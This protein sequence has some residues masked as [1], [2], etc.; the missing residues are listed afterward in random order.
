M[1]NMG[2][3]GRLM[4]F[5]RSYLDNRTFQVRNGTLSDTFEQENGLVQGGVISPILFNIMIDDVCGNVPSEVSRAL[6]A[7]DCSLWVQGRRIFHLV[8]KMQG[9]LNHVSA[10]ADRWG[11]LFSPHKCNAIVFRRYMKARE[12]TN[13]P[14]LHIYN[15]PLTYTDTVKFLGVMLDSRLN[16]NTMMQYIKTK[17]VKRISIL[18]C[19]SGK[20][21]GADRSTL[22]RIYKAMIRPILEYACQVFDGPRNKAVEMIDV[23]QNECIRIATGAFRTSPILPLMVE[24]DILPLRLRRCDLSLRYSL[25]ILS[26]EDHPCRKLMANEAALHEV[27]TGYMKRI[28]GFP[29]Y[30]RILDMC[31]ETGFDFPEEVTLKRSVVPPWRLRKCTLI[32]LTNRSKRT[33]D[34]VQIQCEFNDLRSRYTEYEFIFTDGAKSADGVGCAFV[35][36]ERRQK[37]KLPELCSIF[38]AEGFAVLQ[39]LNYTHTNRILKCVICTDSLSIITALGN[40]TSENPIVIHLLETVSQLIEMGS[41]I[42]V[43]WIPSHSNIRGNETADAQAKM[44]IRLN[45]VC[46]FQMGPKDYFPKVRRSIRELFNK[47]WTDYNPRTNLKRI[48]EE[49]GDWV[50][51]K[52]AVRREEIVLCRLRLG[53]TR[54]THAYMIDRNLQP[55]C[56]RCQCPLTVYHILLECP[57]YFHERR[58]LVTLCQRSGTQFCV[59]SLVGNQFPD[60]IDGVMKYLRHCDVLKQL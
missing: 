17:A 42:I 57:V 56:E 36:G 6:Y 16:L 4:Y 24:A 22:L 30:E 28:S 31:H 18:K 46:N 21:C 27:E 55:E 10:W 19:L 9:A 29:L 34:E 48:K 58:S 52:R 47:Y 54:Y 40:P 53:H 45:D 2:F 44:A 59:R 14:N 1:F 5:V 25:K 7:D 26:R 3:R 50:S 32:K 12:M 11:F 20:G 23:I 8:N 49:V 51:C 43:L 39:A 13:I 33:L 41:I 38:I 37:F 60:I 15:Q 35:H